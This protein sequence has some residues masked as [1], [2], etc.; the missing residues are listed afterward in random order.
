[1]RRLR[2]QFVGPGEGASCLWVRAGGL[3]SHVTAQ[4]KGMPEKMHAPL[5]SEEKATWNLVRRAARRVVSARMCARGGGAWCVSCAVR[6]GRRGTRSTQVALT[7][8]ELHCLVLVRPSPLG[9]EHGNGATEVCS[10]I[11]LKHLRILP[12]CTG[13]MEE[14]R[15]RAFFHLK[16]SC[17]TPKPSTKFVDI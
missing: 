3:V 1:M 12:G 8:V 5:T 17:V 16:Q 13:R 7:L 10:C 14:I 11:R 2:L 15:K 9:R 6:V 4:W